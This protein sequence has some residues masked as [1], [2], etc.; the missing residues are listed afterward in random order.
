MS[1]THEQAESNRRRDEGFD[2]AALAGTAVAAAIAVSINPGPYNGMSFVIGM[3]LLAI[4]FAYERGRPR[5]WRQN[6]ALATVTGFVSLLLV[7]LFLEWWLPSSRFHE[8]CRQ[9]DGHGGSCVQPWMLVTAWSV[10]SVISFVL[11]LYVQR[12]YRGKN[13]YPGGRARETAGEAHLA[14]TPLSPGEKP[15]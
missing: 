4:I 15:A 3:T 6:L 11:D 10:I 7:G 9:A 5:N 2:P 13:P 1:L 14:P 12:W 8:V